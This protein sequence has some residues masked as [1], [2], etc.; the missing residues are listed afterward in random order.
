MN[1]IIHTYL[2]M[3]LT[4]II[5]IVRSLQHIHTV[6]TFVFITFVRITLIASYLRIITV[7]I[8]YI[9]TYDRVITV[10]LSVSYYY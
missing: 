5:H 4:Y 7:I 8:S 10:I 9:I 6:I 2:F 1:L 3:S